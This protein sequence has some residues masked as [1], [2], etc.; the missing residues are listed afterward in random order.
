VLKVGIEVVAR[1]RAQ[2]H[3]HWGPGVWFHAR[4]GRQG[5]RRAS[6]LKTHSLGRDFVL[7]VGPGGGKASNTKHTT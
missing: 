5:N 3:T 4:S 1:S 6:D 2:K 7:E